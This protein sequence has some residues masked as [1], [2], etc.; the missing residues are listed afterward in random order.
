MQTGNIWSPRKSPNLKQTINIFWIKFE[1]A[2]Q[3][4]TSLE[5]LV[6]IL[7]WED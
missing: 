3:V 6:L 4:Q 5:T 1:H 2:Q 7:L